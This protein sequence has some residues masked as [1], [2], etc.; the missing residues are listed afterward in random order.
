LTLSFTL[1]CL[2]ILRP[3]QCFDL[4]AHRLDLTLACSFYSQSSDHF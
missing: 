2:L 3:D 4:V 1:F